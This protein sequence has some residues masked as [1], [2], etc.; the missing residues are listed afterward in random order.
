MILLSQSS[1]F[2]QEQRDFVSPSCQLVVNRGM[3]NQELFSIVGV[4]NNH[5][6][7]PLS[8]GVLVTI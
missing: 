3:N 4:V 2:H 6:N 5:G 7:H 1:T 8:G